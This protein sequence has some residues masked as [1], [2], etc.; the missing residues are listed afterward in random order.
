MDTTQEQ[1]S[2]IIE[3]GNSEQLLAF[4]KS[5]D[6]KQR[7]NLVP[8]IKKDVK[9]LGAYQW[10]EVSIG[11][12]RG[13]SYKQNGTKNQL[14][15]LSV[16]II[17]CYAR[18]DCKN[19]ERNLLNSNNAVKETL[20]WRSP[21]W[22]TDYINGDIKGGNF[23]ISYATLCDWIAEGYVGNITPQVIV[24]KITS[25]SNLEK[26]RFSLDDHIW[27]VFNYPCGVSL[28]DQWYPK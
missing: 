25:A 24:N 26:H 9:R 22:L 17:G 4:L 16:A 10:Y 11:G 28:S 2:K 3:S 21:E 13:G 12:L 6:D 19:I 14:Q 15:M 7:K 8:L 5:L 18:K 1:Y 20:K 27:M 23:S